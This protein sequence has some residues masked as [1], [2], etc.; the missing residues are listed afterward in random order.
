MQK[1]GYQN[2]PTRN[3]KPKSTKNN[4]KTKTP[5][6]CTQG[7]RSEGQTDAPETS[8]LSRSFQR[9]SD[10]PSFL[11][12]VARLM[13]QV[14]KIPQMPSSYKYVATSDNPE[15]IS[16]YS[17]QQSETFFHILLLSFGIPGQDSFIALLLH[18]HGFIPHIC[19]HFAP[20]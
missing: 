13:I 8:A 12:P 18:L 16:P 7:T 6:N 20:V 4:P 15:V 5:R 3:K 2:T 9:K 10:F 11:L 14:Q 17:F 1:P 19:Q